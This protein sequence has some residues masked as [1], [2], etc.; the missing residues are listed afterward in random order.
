MH[1]DQTC[2]GRTDRAVRELPLREKRA[3]VGLGVGPELRFLPLV[4]TLHLLKVRLHRIQVD[5]LEALV[6][7]DGVAVFIAAWGVPTLFD[8]DSVSQFVGEPLTQQTV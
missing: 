8:H 4:E 6:L 3:F 2:A 1:F 7:R 5:H